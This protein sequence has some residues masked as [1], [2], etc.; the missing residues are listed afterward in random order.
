[1]LTASSTDAGYEGLETT[2]DVS[3]TENDCGAWGTYWAD[4]NGDC[5]VDIADLAEWASSWLACTT[6]NEPGCVDMR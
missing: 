5:I 3:I 1:M 4:F 2:V 6:P